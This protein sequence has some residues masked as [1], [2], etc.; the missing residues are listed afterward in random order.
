MEWAS[1]NLTPDSVLEVNEGGNNAFGVIPNLIRNRNVER[2]LSCHSEAEAEELQSCT[3]NNIIAGED[4]QSQNRAHVVSNK[5]LNYSASTLPCNARSS[6]T[7]GAEIQDDMIVQ[8][9]QALR[10]SAFTKGAFSYPLLV[11]RIAS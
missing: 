10:T 9:P 6:Q 1:C 4:L 2:N 8:N 3:L 5:I 7:R 11:K